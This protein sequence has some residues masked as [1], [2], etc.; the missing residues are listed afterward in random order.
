MPSAHRLDSL[1]FRS[2]KCWPDPSKQIQRRPVPVQGLRLLQTTLKRYAGD[3]LHSLYCLASVEGASLLKTSL[4]QND[5]PTFRALEDAAVYLELLC[6]PIG[7][8]HRYRSRLQRSDDGF[9]LREYGELSCRAW[10]R[11]R[12]SSA[13][14]A[15]LADA[16]DGQMKSA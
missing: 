5:C 14:N 7:L 2:D 11:R 16:R 8:P 1:P 15:R 9:M 4:Q 3:A 12:D 13:V 6:G 10:Q